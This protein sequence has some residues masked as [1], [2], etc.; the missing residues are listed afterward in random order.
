MLF[1]IIEILPPNDN[2]KACSLWHYIFNFP[3]I[4]L[5]YAG[6]AGGPN[7]NTVAVRSIAP[8]LRNDSLLY[9]DRHADGISA[10]LMRGIGTFGRFYNIAQPAG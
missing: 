2:N 7:Q 1:A 4:E 3:A 9:V 10:D 6:N 8:Y 5:R